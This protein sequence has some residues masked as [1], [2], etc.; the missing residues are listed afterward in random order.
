MASSADDLKKLYDALSD[1]ERAK[2]VAMLGGDAKSGE[3]DKGGEDVL[4]SPS[5]SS[6]LIHAGSAGISPQLHTAPS[7][8]NRVL[9]MTFLSGD[10]RAQVSFS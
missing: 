10:I 7:K 5:S 3:R 6:R 4:V 9:P 2:F 1:S 8:K